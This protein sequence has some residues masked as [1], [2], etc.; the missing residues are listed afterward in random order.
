M[1]DIRET[2]GVKTEE[3]KKS[4]SLRTGTGRERR[5]WRSRQEMLEPR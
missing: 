1:S 4:P 5:R 2:R 3:E